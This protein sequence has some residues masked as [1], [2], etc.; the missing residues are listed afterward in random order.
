MER[1]SS[2]IGRMFLGEKKESKK[3]TDLA[4]HPKGKKGSSA[5]WTA[6]KPRAK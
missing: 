1:I 6:S 4:R 2:I 3:E 5:V